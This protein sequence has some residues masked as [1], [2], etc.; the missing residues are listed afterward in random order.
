MEVDLVA[1]RV[2]N[3]V[4]Y[5]LRRLATIAAALAAFATLVSVATFFTGW[6][7]FANS[8]AA[9]AVIGGVLC[10]IPTV[11]G[12]GAW[13]VIRW[14]ARLAPRLLTD[15]DTFLRTPSPAAQTLIDYDSGQPIAASARTFGSMK[16]DVHARKT[17]IPALYI[18]V[19][20]ITIVPAMAGVALGGG[21]LLGAFG[22]VLFLI[23]LFQ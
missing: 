10:L 1:Q 7:V 15:I 22:T 5:T 6:W 3:G 13:I 20:S 16:A 4:A 12:I 21:L 14:A 9:W 17:D 11:A 2:G 8:R 18:V 23:G 19:R